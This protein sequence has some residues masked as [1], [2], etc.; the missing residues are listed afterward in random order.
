MAPISGQDRTMLE[1]VV[2]LTKD[3]TRYSLNR[4]YPS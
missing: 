4:L 3:A 1:Y 2:K